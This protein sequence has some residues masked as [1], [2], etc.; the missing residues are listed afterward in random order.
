MDDGHPDRSRSVGIRASGV[1]KA[2]RSRG[3]EIR[4]LDGLDL[5]VYDREFFCLLGPSGCGKSTFLRILSGLLDHDAGTIEI[6]T[7]ARDGRPT[8]SLVFQEQGIFPWK[9]VIDNVAFGLK[10]RGVDRETRY[11]TARRYIDK[12]NLTG[13]EDSYPHQLSGGMK[14]RVGIARAFAN[15]PEILLMDEPFGDLDAQTKRY[16]QE[17]LL[18]LW[19]DSKK[20]VVYVTHDIEEAITLGDRLGI[21]TA[22]P[23]HVKE[24]LEVGIDRPRH[25]DGLST[26]RIEELKDR[27]WS[28]LSDE[29]ERTVERE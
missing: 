17:E 16:L 26:G 29:V 6:E 7:A 19:N 3:D 11:E 25:R 20:T 2:Y 21:M 5:T 22:R 23:G 4:A 8:T 27:V 14:Q 10:M 18:S 9:T 15:D 24:V 12:V 13:F 28:V 1:S